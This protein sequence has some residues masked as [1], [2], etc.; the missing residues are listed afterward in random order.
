MSAMYNDG[1]QP[2]G[3]PLDYGYND[4]MEENDEYELG[5]GDGGTYL[6]C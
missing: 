5:E 1:T 2:V 6:Y 3:D 4:D